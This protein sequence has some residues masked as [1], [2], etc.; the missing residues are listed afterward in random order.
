MKRKDHDLRRKLVK[1]GLNPSTAFE[2]VKGGQITPD[3]FKTLGESAHEVLRSLERTL[4][5]G[6]ED[7]ETTPE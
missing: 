4:G 2:V 1:D 3:N 5:K 6:A 7:D